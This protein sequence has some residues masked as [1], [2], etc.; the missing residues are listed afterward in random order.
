V[1]VA[2]SIWWL[3][4]SFPRFTPAA[5]SLAFAAQVGDSS[6]LMAWL[7]IQYS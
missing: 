4:K 2:L 7:S 5:F 1:R 6:M 3:P